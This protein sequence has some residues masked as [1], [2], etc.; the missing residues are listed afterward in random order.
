MN[1][2]RSSDRGAAPGVEAPCTSASRT[3][4]APGASRARTAVIVCHGMGEQVPFETLNSVAEAL[5]KRQSDAPMDASKARVRYATFGDDWLPRVEL[6]LR[7]PGD[8]LCDIHLY[9]VYWAP[10]TEGKVTARDALGFLI[11]AGLR[12]IRYCARG[13]F[14][15]WMFGRRLEFRLPRR[16]VLQLGAALAALLALLVAFAGVA[17]AA[18]AE[19]VRFMHPGAMPPPPRWLPALPEAWMLASLAAALIVFWCLRSFLVQSVG[20]VAAYISAHRASRFTEI[21]RAIQDAARSVARNVYAARDDESGEPRYA[22]VLMVGHSLGSVIA[23]DILGDSINRDLAAAAAG[24]Q[25]L[26]VVR[27]TKLLL[28][29]GSPLDKTAFLFRTQKDDA[30]L[31]EALAAAAQP[32][33]VSYANR[34][35]RWVNIWSPF[36][37]ISGS[38]EY[39]DPPG[40]DERPPDGDTS[41]SD[42]SSTGGRPDA[43]ALDASRGSAPGSDPAAMSTIAPRT[44]ENIRERGV[45]LDTVRAHLGYWKR[46]EFGKQLFDALTACAADDAQGVS[47]RDAVLPATPPLRSRVEL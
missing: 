35:A 13:S 1:R 3:P 18:A 11:G 14:D 19:L 22:H 21:R 38:L 42:V 30:P 47:A 20:D 2:E 7:T 34:P 29:L 32:M 17:A 8:G 31:R 40:S 37:W 28:T 27:R 4:P 16:G 46:A 9:E 5:W 39:Y 10:L 24:G 45:P 12:G 26:D 15:R 25:V 36:D 23:Y 43:S 33:I 6:T 41:T 44:V